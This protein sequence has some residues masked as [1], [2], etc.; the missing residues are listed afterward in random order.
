MRV[1]TRKAG[2]GV[3][4]SLT[5]VAATEFVLPKGEDIAESKKVAER[6]LSVAAL[7]YLWESVLMK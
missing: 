6:L 1:S 7:K 5:T 2:K 4:G 3:V